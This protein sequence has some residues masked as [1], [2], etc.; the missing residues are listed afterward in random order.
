M[1]KTVSVILISALAL[2]TVC[3]TAC[4]KKQEEAGTTAA[5]SYAS[6]QEVTESQIIASVSSAGS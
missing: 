2:G 3:L 4:G 5:V 1:K 6:V